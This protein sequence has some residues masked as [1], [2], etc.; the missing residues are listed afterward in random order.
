MITK[1]MQDA[2]NEQVKHEID[3]A[4]IYLSMAANFHDQGWEGMAHWMR[5]QSHEERTH[6]EKFFKHLVERE[7][8]VELKAVAQ[9][10]NGWATPLE[11]FKEAY[12]HEK[13]ITGKI[14]QMVKLAEEEKDYAASVLLN[15]FVDEQVEEEN[16]A[17]LIVQQLERVGDSAVGL[18]V[19][20]AELGKRE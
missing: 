7:S 16:N 12:K 11:A 4:Y 5:K 14:N 20:D 13:F 2:I 6:A 17:A 19:L 1:K 15:W 10:K 3:S 9:P 18:Y 8:R